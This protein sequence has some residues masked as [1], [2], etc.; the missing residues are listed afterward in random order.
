MNTKE[1]IGLYN[2]YVMNTYTRVPVALAKGKGSRVWDLEQKEYLDFFP[3]WGVSGLGHCHQKIY[4]AIKE[5]AG[6]IIHVSNNYYNHLQGRLAREIIDSSFEG[7]VFFCN[8]GAEANEAAFKLARSFGQGR[9]FEF[10]SFENSFHG[11]TFAAVSA[12]GQTKYQKGF[13]PLVPGF[14]HILFNDI[15]AVK[16]AVNEKTAAII[17][18]PI[19]GEG[20]INVAELNF[21]REL[22][23]ICDRNKILLIVD[24]VQTGMG[25]T[26]K[27]FCYQHYGIIP[28]IMTLAKSIGGGLPIGAMVAGKEIAEFFKPGMHASTFGGSPLVCKAALAVFEIIR[29]EK[30]LKNCLDM[31]MYLKGKLETLKAKFDF[32]R[33]VRGMG[34]MLAME[35][36]R[37]GKEIVEKCMDGGLLINCTHEKVLRIMPALNVKKKEI[38]KAVNVLE[39]VLSEEPVTRVQ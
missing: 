2:Q 19:Q 30:L 5:Q 27:L 25:R 38:D 39:K 20:G 35:L 15:R 7:K 37:P 3:G 24:E 10:I 9:K 28:D 22:R 21:L 29:K 8:S 17:I 36:D 31:G 16:A 11:R 34:L 4:S 14:F 12:T 13:E 26:G 23:E 6:K 32:I 33:E 1:T 18:E